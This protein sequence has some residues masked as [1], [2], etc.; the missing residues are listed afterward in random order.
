[1]IEG[2]ATGGKGKRIRACLEL[3]RAPNL[4]TAMADSG[5]GFLFTHPYYTPG[6]GWRLTLLVA[7]STALYAA[8]VVLNDVFDFQEDCL[9]RPARPLP[10]GRIS[11]AA[12]RWLG[13]GLLAVGVVLAAVASHLAASALPVIVAVSLA[14]LIVAYDGL[15]KRTVVGPPAMGGCRLGNVL[16]GM[17]AATE[18]WR[19]EHWLIAAAVGIY[20]SGVT[21][22]ARTEARRSSRWQLGLATLVLLAGIALLGWL[23]RLAEHTVPL[24]LRQPFRWVVLLMALGGLIGLRCLRAVVRPGP[25]QVQMA[26]RHC[27]FSLV[28]LDAA[29][30]F[31]VQGLGGALV[32]LALLVP[33][34]LLGQWVYST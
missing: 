4:F 3:V 8:G 25:A 10:S 15:L 26:V 21:W 12:A 32:I 11:V 30:C 14:A 2:G 24:L 33:A 27:I 20:V 6:D 29:I 18:P 34:L 28:I 16:L 22:F 5:M 13:W 7:A 31:V 9:E 1:V 19:G 23:P 17:S